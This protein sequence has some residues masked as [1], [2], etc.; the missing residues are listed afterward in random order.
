MS[1][2]T[3][4][5][6]NKL[7]KDASLQFMPTAITYWFRV[8]MSGKGPLAF[9]WKDKPHRLVSDLC[10][11]LEAD[12]VLRNSPPTM[13]SLLN[14]ARALASKIEALPNSLAASKAS[15]A[16]SEAVMALQEIRRSS[17]PSN[18]TRKTGRSAGNAEGEGSSPSR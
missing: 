1:G 18:A 9:E 2:P 3:K 10:L 5:Q 6:L 16:V 13:T 4:R 12:E 17:K 15:L 14:E 11:I 7:Q 8:A